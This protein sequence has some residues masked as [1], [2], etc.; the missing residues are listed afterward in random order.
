ML[1]SRRDEFGSDEL[2][3]CPSEELDDSDRA[4]AQPSRFMCARHSDMKALACCSFNPA[5]ARSPTVI[6]ASTSKIESSSSCAEYDIQGCRHTGMSGTS[7]PLV[8]NLAS[9]P[10]NRWPPEFSSRRRKS[11]KPLKR[12]AANCMNADKSSLRENFH[13]A[14]EETVGQKYSREWSCRRSVAVQL[15]NSCAGAL[16]VAPE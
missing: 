7:E 2:H 16:S 4:A 3:S 10:T 8:G 9:H 11:V 13:A 15:K 6:S 12:P 1:A 14:T 5:R